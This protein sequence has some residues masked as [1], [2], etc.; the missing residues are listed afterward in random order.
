MKKNELEFNQ[1]YDRFHDK[2]SNYLERMVGKD[3]SEDL[4]QEV[5]IKIDKG[6]K[7]FKGK[8]TLSTWIYRISTNTALDRIRSRSFQKQNKQITINESSNELDKEDDI[9]L[10]D[11]MSLSAEREA[12]SNEMNECIREFVD[13]LPLDYRT[14][15]IL[16]EIKD[17]K[18]Q[19]IADILGV[20]IDTAKIRLHRAR[21]KLKEIFEAGC[22]FYRDESGKLACDRKQKKSEN[23]GD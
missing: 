21:A 19:E 12:I 16:S 18:N 23:H 13:N 14:V 17:L 11:K 3:E 10:I 8:S 15:I 9:L 1:V 22:D 2:V 5:F 4:T 20:S 6:L 7:E